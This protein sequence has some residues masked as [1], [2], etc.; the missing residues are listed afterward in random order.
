MFGSTIDARSIHCSFVDATVSDSFDQFSR[1]GIQ[2][3]AMRTSTSVRERE[4]GATGI[5]YHQIFHVHAL[6]D[7]HGDHILEEFNVEDNLHD[8][9]EFI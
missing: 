9:V 2:I 8:D 4:R 1:V 6:I 3:L 5:V 7:D